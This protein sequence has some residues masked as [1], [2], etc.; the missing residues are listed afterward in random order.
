MNKLIICYP[1]KDIL[2]ENCTPN[3]F[4]DK[5]LIIKLI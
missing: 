4:V 3:R 5:I 1:E 2:E